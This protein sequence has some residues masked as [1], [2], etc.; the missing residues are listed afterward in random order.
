MK[1]Q[2][3]S[4]SH[5]TTQPW[6]W[7]LAARE[8]TTLAGAPQPRW[9]RVDSGRLW[10]TARDGGPHQPDL[11]LGPGDSLALP[12]GTAWVVEAVACTRA[13]LLEAAP[14]RLSAGGFLAAWRALPARLAARLV[15]MAA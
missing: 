15:P 11:W 3:M 4:L 2:P 5:Q 12:P 14:R 8:A 10:V 7:R 9:L 1:P 6:A 13:S